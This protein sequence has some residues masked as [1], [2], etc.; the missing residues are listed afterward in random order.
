[1]TTIK[2]DFDDILIVPKVHGDISSRY[3][4]IILPDKLPLFTAPMDT[5]V[6]YENKNIFLE[7]KINVVLPRTVPYLQFL[8]KEVVAGIFEGGRV[9]GALD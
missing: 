6:N 8:A 4:D 7:N 2:F 9:P 5:V 3:K 1:M